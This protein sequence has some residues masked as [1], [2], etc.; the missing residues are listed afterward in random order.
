MCIRDRYYDAQVAATRTLVDT[1]SGST[2]SADELRVAAETVERMQ[3]DAA[4]RAELATEILERALSSLH[5]G[6]LK[7]DSGVS[8]FRSSLTE[9][10]LREGLERS[11]RDM[12]RYA[13][14]PAQKIALID[15]ANKVRPVSLL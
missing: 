10:A 3:L 15:R 8:L 13:P 6:S 11:Y 9:E 4:E 2:P 7:P 1:S 14:D 5:D 12:A